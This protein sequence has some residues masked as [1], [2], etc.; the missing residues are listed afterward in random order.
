MSRHLRC[1]YILHWTEALKD[2]VFFEQGKSTV[3]W[4]LHRIYMYCIVHEDSN[5][6][7]V[8]YWS[9]VMGSKMH[10]PDIMGI[11]TQKAVCKPDVSGELLI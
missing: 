7:R 5:S 8:V 11:S 10:P 6:P 1:F 4:H 9:R 3:R 2:L